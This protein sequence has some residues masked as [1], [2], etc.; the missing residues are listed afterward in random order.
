VRVLVVDDEVRFALA[1][2]RGL[3]AEGFDVDVAHDGERG[4]DLARGG[5]Y[6]AVVLDVMLPRLSGYRVVQRLREQ[7]SAVPVLMVSAKDGEY[8]QADGLDLGAD[9]Y[10]TK[11]FAWVVFVARLKALLRRATGRAQ[12]PPAGPVAVGDLVLDPSAHTVTR[13]GTPVGLTAREF[14]LLEHLMRA[15]GRTVPKTELLSAVWNGLAHDDPN[16]VE[17][18]VGYLRRKID[19][20]FERHS[21]VTVRGVGYRLVR[22]DGAPA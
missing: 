8:D 7:G 4:L 18:Y 1:V 6:D 17:V 9:D 20:P 12:G 10:L 13:G 3:R 21:L 5:D 16:V 19:Q 22:D 15:D 11:P 2:Q 14:D